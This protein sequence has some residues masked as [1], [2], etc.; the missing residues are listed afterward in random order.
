M[1]IAWVLYMRGENHTTVR[2][3][4]RLGTLD[5][6]NVFF[7]T[8]VPDIHKMSD[9]RFISKQKRIICT[10]RVCSLYGMLKHLYPFATSFILSVTK[11]VKKLLC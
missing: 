10:N 1:R 7:E 8:T 3:N 5:I 11:G 6:D 2:L 4:R 9:D